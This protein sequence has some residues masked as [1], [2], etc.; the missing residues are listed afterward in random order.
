MGGIEKRLE[1]LEK[2]CGMS[3]DAAQREGATE[4]LRAEL[5]A[6]LQRIIDQEEEIEPWRLAALEE[7]R[8][9]SEKRRR[10]HGA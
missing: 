5:R 7:L 2:R 10:E 9:S 3:G 6:R 1:D 8:E 4:E